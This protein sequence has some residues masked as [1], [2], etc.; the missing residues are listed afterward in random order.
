MDIS[1]IDKYVLLILKSNGWSEHRDFHLADDWIHKIEQNGV[2]CFDC[3]KRILHS[4]GGIKIR[5]PSP[6]V[7]Q[8]FLKK[9]NGDRKQLKKWY[10]RPLT[11]L[12]S[13]KEKSSFEMYT[14]ATFQFDALNAFWNQEIVIDIKTAEKRIG[15]RLFPIGTVEP[16]GISYAAEKGS[17]YTLFDDSIFLSGDNIESYLNMLFIKQIKPKQIM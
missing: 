4:L 10:L 12:E 11:I 13:L 1:Q 3:A 7:A 15:E 5:E 8:Y 2:P 16:D 9:C 17:I 6:K 14:G